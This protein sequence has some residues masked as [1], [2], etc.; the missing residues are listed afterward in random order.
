M[1]AVGSQFGWSLH[2]AR[3]GATITDDAV[4]VRGVKTGGS[5]LLNAS[6]A[7]AVDNPGPDQLVFIEVSGSLSGTNQGAVD[8]DGEVIHGVAYSASGEFTTAFMLIEPEADTLE[9]LEQA[10][11]GGRRYGEASP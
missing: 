8:N 5:D 2:S 11:V 10:C 4:A 6:S 9:Y 7:S 1:I 3:P